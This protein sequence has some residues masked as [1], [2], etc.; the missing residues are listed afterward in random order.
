[1]LR[2]VLA[3]INPD[4]KTTGVASM[5]FDSDPSDSGLDTKRWKD[6]KFPAG[7]RARATFELMCSLGCDPKALL[8]F[9]TVAVYTSQKEQS[10]YESYGVSQSVLVKLPEKLE[11]IARE[12]EP[13]NL[14]FEIYLTAFCVENT[15]LSDQT[16]SRCREKGMVYKNIP[17]ML[18]TLAMDLRASNPRLRACAGPRGYNS[19]RHSVLMLL[20]YVRTSTK[21]PHYEAVADLLD[22]LFGCDAKILRSLAEP[23]PKRARTGIGKKDHTP[24]LLTS[25][26]AL[27][28]LYY[29]SATKYGFRKASES[30]QELSP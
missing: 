21:S 10:V 25:A 7:S 6:L 20:E 5:A 22:H 4:N 26:D 27:K 2:D 8:S 11:K 9:L 29:R 15:N 17:K 3:V 30:R 13:V 18:R 14:L 28:A 1:M 19:F 12:L 16:R 24:K 23:P